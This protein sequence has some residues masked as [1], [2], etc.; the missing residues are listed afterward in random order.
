[1]GI[2]LDPSIFG[3]SAQAIEG[4]NCIVSINYVKVGENAIKSVTGVGASREG[5]EWV[6]GLGRSKAGVST[7]GVWTPRDVTV[8]V[9]GAYTNFAKQLIGPFGNYQDQLFS[10]SLQF[11]KPLQLFGLASIISF[12]TLT[13]SLNDC[14]FMGDSQG[15]DVG[16]GVIVDE[17][18]IRPTTIDVPA[19]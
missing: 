5:A 15:I 10:L 7:W 4:R 3:A 18:T 17:W 19:G 14:I 13:Y 1:M 11:E 8:Q 2:I 12:P 6:T 16:G 9:F